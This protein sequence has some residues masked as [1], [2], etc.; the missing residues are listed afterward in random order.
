LAIAEFRSVCCLQ[1]GA[2]RMEFDR[3]TQCPFED[4]R[5]CIADPR[6]SVFCMDMNHC[7]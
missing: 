7:H 5:E 2:I 4:V 6:P 3:P 1:G